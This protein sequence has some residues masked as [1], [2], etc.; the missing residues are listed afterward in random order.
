MDLK[1]TYNATRT[2]QSRQ[3][4][5]DVISPN[6]ISLR[7]STHRILE[8][9]EKHLQWYAHTHPND[10]KDV[11]GI[12]KQL[13]KE[14]V[15]QHNLGRQTANNAKS[16]RDFYSDGRTTLCK[17]DI[18][19]KYVAKKMRCHGVGGIEALTGIQKEEED[20]SNGDCAENF[21]LWDFDPGDGGRVWNWTVGVWFWHFWGLE[22][23]IRWLRPCIY[24]RDFLVE[25]SCGI[26][27]VSGGVVIIQC[28]GDCVSLEFVVSGK[29]PGYGHFV[30][31]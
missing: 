10:Y 22:I 13:Q 12:L 31:T 18:L 16:S 19:E 17:T 21:W 11:F 29:C 5:C 20:A 1:A 23:I 14:K 9:S 8:A 15:V 27:A 25:F 26:F 3:F 2:F 30:C 28:F 6:I 7:D 24:L 4:T